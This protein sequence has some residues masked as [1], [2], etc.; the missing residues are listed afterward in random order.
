MEI[1]CTIQEMKVFDLVAVGDALVDIFLRIT[2]PCE[3]LSVDNT[4]RSLLVRIGSKIPV[5]DSV[6]SLGGDACNVAV[7]SAKLGLRAAI[8]AEIGDDDLSEKIVKELRSARVSLD[9][10]KQTKHASSTFSVVVTVTNDRTIFSRHIVREHMFSFDHLSTQWIYLTSLG[11]KWRET[12]RKTINFVRRGD[13]KLAFSPGSHQLKDGRTSFHDVLPIT[14]I[15]F[16]NREEGEKIAYGH[17]YVVGE[18]RKP[19]EVVLRDLKALGPKIVSLTDGENGS[20][21]I[22][23][24]GTIYSQGIVPSRV[25]EKTGVGD[26]YAAGFLAG[27]IHGRQIKETMRWGAANSAAVIGHIGSV[28]GL[29]SLRELE[30]QLMK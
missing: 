22:D 17:E 26:A 7:S 6:I 2:S 3:D 18:E 20:Y 16:L 25:I 8:M 15:L 29:L 24:V 1:L 13:T 12:Y 4:S 11:E 28:T 14:D 23:S 19:V 10:L 9:Y 30:S 5:D 21:A 27:V